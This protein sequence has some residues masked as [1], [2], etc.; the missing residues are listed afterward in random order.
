[1]RAFTMSDRKAEL[2]RKKAKLQAIREEKERRR[3]EKEQKEAEEAALRASHPERDQHKEL[4]EM[5]TLLGVAPVSD[6]LSHLSSLSSSTPDQSGTP[7]PE[8]SLQSTNAASSFSNSSSRRAAQLSF[9]NVQIT[10]IPPVE[11]VTYGKQTQTVH[12]GPE[13]D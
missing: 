5:L 12:T 1:M 6:V 7:T 3:R 10:D 4:D 13:R 11:K 2:E 9:T 8:P